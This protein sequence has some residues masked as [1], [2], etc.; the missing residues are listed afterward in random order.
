MW[1]RWFQKLFPKNKPVLVIDNDGDA[2]PGLLLGED[3]RG[4]Y[5]IDPV[6]NPLLIARS[7]VCKIVGGLKSAQAFGQAVLAHRQ[8]PPPAEPTEEDLEAV[9]TSLWGAGS[10]LKEQH[11]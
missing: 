10:K 9:R 4:I 3:R 5:L 11:R 7:E 6:G 2:I 1:R 8:E